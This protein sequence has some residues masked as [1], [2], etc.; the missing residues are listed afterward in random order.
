[1]GIFEKIKKIISKKTQN[2]EAKMH[3][4]DMP[5]E[6]KQDFAFKN[7]PK[8]ENPL[9]FEQNNQQYPQQQFAPQKNTQ[10]QNN[11]FSRQDN[12]QNQNYQNLN[13]VNA[14]QVP[15]EEPAPLSI[16]PKDN[17][18]EMEKLD[19]VMIELRT[20]KAQNVQVLSEL[21]L[22]QDRLRRIY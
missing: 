3:Y 9:V 6:L 16:G 21:R 7:K 15:F 8:Q 22:L 13:N 10:Q 18:P 1:M 4:N 11:N 2:N 14:E 5:N 12:F 19:S 20:I 17:S